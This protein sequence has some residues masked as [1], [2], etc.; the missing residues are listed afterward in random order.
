MLVKGDWIMRYVFQ[1][2]SVYQKKNLLRKHSLASS[3]YSL[4]IISQ[5]FVQ[6][7]LLLKCTLSSNPS[8]GKICLQTN[9]PLSIIPEVVEVFIYKP[10]TFFSS[11]HS[12][13]HVL[14]LS[15]TLWTVSMEAAAWALAVTVVNSEQLCSVCLVIRDCAAQTRATGMA[16]LMEVLPADGICFAQKGGK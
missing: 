6:E 11:Y 4:P 9:L 2:V 12:F 13:K 3:A 5:R 7:P 8:T 1:W 16:I 14:H 10:K 15:G